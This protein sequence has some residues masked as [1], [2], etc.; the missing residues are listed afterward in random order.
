MD[1]ISALTQR[2]S[3]AKLQEPGPTAAQWQDI[4][5]AAMRAADHGQM[6]PWRFLTVE[7]EARKK[8][9][10]LYCDSALQADPKLPETFQQKFKN[11]PL[12]APAIL[13]VIACCESHPKVPMAEQVISA[14][15]AAQNAINA[16]YALGLGAMWR[17]GD[18]AHDA[19]VKRGLGLGDKEQL[20]GYIYLGT[21]S[22]SKSL[23]PM[24]ELDEKCQAWGE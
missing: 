17:T 20:I 6:R 13:V 24:P 11:M 14:G 23:P 21:P 18:M 2:V 10:Q 15:A 7:G 12:R 4:L 22:T 8:L 3:I 5:Q 9:G 19:N 16:A 1:A